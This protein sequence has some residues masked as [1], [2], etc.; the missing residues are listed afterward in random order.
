MAK[1]PVK[2]PTPKTLGTGY[3]AKAASAAKGRNA[4]MQAE[5]DKMFPPKKKK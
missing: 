5:I 2:K 3:A 1:K 4:K